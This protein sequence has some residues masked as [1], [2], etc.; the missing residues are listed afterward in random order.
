MNIREKVTILIDVDDTIEDLIPAWVRWLNN[1]HHLSVP[2]DGIDCWEIYKHFPTLTKKQVYAPLYIKKFWETVEPKKDAVAYVQK[3]YEEGYDVYLCTNSNYE[4][5]H[6]KIGYIID[7][8][9]P[10]M[11][12]RIIT[13]SKKQMLKADFLID[14]NPGNLIG[15]DYNKILFE[16][17]HNKNLD[18]YKKRQ[19]Y[20]ITDSWEKIYN[21]ITDYTFINWLFE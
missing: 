17:G 8:Y 14:D 3:I 5:I 1:K 2:E 16:C 18:E 21:A 15:G 13:I 19:M 12:D 7:R 4:T 6:S 20:L 9:F 10:Y 11:R